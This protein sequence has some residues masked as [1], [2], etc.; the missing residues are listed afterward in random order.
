MTDTLTAEV[1]RETTIHEH[2]GKIVVDQSPGHQFIWYNDDLTS[3]SGK[4]TEYMLPMPYTRLVMNSSGGY[5]GLFCG[6]DKEPYEP[7]TNPMGSILPLPTVAASFTC[8]NLSCRAS[9][10]VEEKAHEMVL[11]FWGSSFCAHPMSPACW[12]GGGFWESFGVPKPA[13]EYYT[14]LAGNNRAI[15]EVLTAWSKLTIDEVMEKDFGPRS[16]IPP[17]GRL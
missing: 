13:K 9:G 4:L 2:A 7:G 15:H 17:S 1:V 16:T 3:H 10:T 14:D 12:G 5:G 8:C 11:M 6:I